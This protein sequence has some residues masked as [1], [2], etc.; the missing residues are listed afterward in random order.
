MAFTERFSRTLFGGGARSTLGYA[1]FFNSDTSVQYVD[2]ATK[3]FASA[4]GL[5]P[6]MTMALY[7]ERM[8]VGSSD[9]PM[10]GD[11]G[12]RQMVLERVRGAGRFLGWN[13]G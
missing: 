11:E 12:L 5:A 7:P 6:R 4:E 13:F 10:L 3:I 2:G 8:T 1:V 9:G